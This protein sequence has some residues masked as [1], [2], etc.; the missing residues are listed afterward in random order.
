VLLARRSVMATVGRFVT[1]P[2][3]RRYCHLTL[4]DRERIVVRH[5][6]ETAGAGCLIIETVRWWGLLPGTTLMRF[7]LEMPEGREA[8]ARLRQLAPRNAGA[9]PLAALVDYLGKCRSLRDVGV[10]CRALLV[11]GPPAA[12]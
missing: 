7:D 12:A 4:D 6:P 5:D 1:D 11:P 9:T 10:R 2:A 3:G 8:L